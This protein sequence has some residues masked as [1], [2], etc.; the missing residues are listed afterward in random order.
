MVK[1]RA[2]LEPNGILVINEP[3]KGNPIIS[4]LR[5]IRKQI[6]STY[7]GDQVEFSESELRNMFTKCGYKVR[8]FPQGILSTP[9]TEVHLLPD[10]IGTPFAMLMEVIEP[11]IENAIS[12][13]VLRKLSWNI[14]V[15]ARI[16]KEKCVK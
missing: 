9:F 15:E 7:S 13:S 12:V 4:I 1:I 6:D 14:V 3:Q 16:L 8:T 2:F 10:V 5:R 11:F